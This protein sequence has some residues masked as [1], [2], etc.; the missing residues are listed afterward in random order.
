MTDPDPIDFAEFRP[1][2]AAQARV[3]ELLER[4]K[5]SQLSAEESAELDRF[6]ELEHILRVAKA[7]ARLI[8]A[9]RI[10]DR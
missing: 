4:E 6:V 1:A 10:Q 2:A 3:V 7:R 5:E 9:A 8:L